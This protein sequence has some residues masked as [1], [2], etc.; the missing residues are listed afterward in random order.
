M[1][2][3]PESSDEST[4]EEAESKQAELLRKREDIKQGML[5]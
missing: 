3:L 5:D 2:N 4:V 1:K